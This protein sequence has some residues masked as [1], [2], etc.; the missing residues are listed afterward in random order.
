M[1]C[2]APVSCPTSAV[3]QYRVAS[4]SWLRHR[5]ARLNRTG[6]DQP[7]RRATD[8]PNSDLVERV[9]LD[10]E[11]VARSKWPEEF[12]C[13][14]ASYLGPGSG[15]ARERLDHKLEND[16]ARDH[17]VARKVPREIRLVRLDSDSHRGGMPHRRH[18]LP[19]RG[20]QIARAH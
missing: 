10:V 7:A 16:R 11:L 17:G 4:A 15:A 8:K 9:Q 3:P 6:R 18:R 1:R 2:F 13:V 14:N 12:D 19:K 20:A 5:G